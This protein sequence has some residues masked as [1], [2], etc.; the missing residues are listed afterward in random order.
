MRWLLVMRLRLRLRLGMRW[1]MC[2]SVWSVW[3]DGHRVADIQLVR[4][5]LRTRLVHGILLRIALEAITNGVSHHR[6]RRRH[7]ER[8]EVGQMVD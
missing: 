3:V 5:L 8:D 6:R 1:R 4:W 7:S 2:R